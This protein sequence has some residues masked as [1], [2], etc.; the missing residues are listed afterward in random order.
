MV[1]RQRSLAAAPRLALLLAAVVTAI[2]SGQTSTTTFQL[3]G[4]PT[5]L[6]G[7]A[8]GSTFN[9][10]IGP[11]GTLVVAGTG[12]V[13]FGP[14][15]AATGV[16]FRPGGWQANDIAYY[17]F[18]GQA[19]G[20]IFNVNGGD[21]TFL[22]KSRSSFANR[23]LGY[24]KWVFDVYD[25][26][27]NLFTFYVATNSGTLSFNYRA[28][29]VVTN[30]YV[31]PPGQED[32]MFGSGVVLKV[33]VAWNGSRVYL[34]LN[35]AL[36][37]TRTY[38]PV[39]PTWTAASSFVIGTRQDLTYGAGYFSWDDWVSQLVVTSAASGSPPAKVGSPSPATGAVGVATTSALSW[40]ASSGATSYDVYFGHTLPAF[41]AAANLAATTFAPSGPLPTATSYV[42]RVDAKNAFG[43]TAGD[44]WSFTTAGPPLPPKV[45]SPSPPHGSANVAVSAAL[46]WAA[47]TGATTYDLYVGT[48]LPGSPTWTNMTGTT[49]SPPGGFA[50]STKYY[51]RVDAKNASGATAGDVWSFTTSAATPPPPKP[52]TPSPAH[53][54]TNVG[55][56]TTLAWAGSAGATGYDVYLGTTLPTAPTVSGL[57]ATTYAPGA[58]LAY[59]T[60]YSWRVDAKNGGGTTAGDVWTFTTGPAP[61]VSSVTVTSTADAAIHAVV[62][63]SNLGHAPVVTLYAGSSALHAFSLPP[64]P[65][66]AVLLSARLQ[67]SVTGYDDGYPMMADEYCVVGVYRLTRPWTEGGVTHNMA[68]ATTAWTAAGGDYDST[69]DFGHGAN[70][71]VA[72]ALSRLSQTPES[73][74]FDVTALV[75]KWYSNSHPNYGFLL[76]QSDRQGGPMMNFKEVADTTKRPM[77][78]IS[79]AVTTAAPTVVSVMPSN[80]AANRPVDQPITLALNDLVGIN[81]G[82]LSFLVN[83]V[84]RASQV[85]VSGPQRSPTLTYAPA[86]AFGHATSVNAT[87]SIQNWSGYTLTS[88]ITFTVA[89]TDTVAPVVARGFPRAGATNVPTTCHVRVL[90]PGPRFGR[91]LVDAVRQIERDR[92]H[93]GSPDASRE[94]RVP[95]APHPAIS[96]AGWTASDVHGHQLR[97]SAAAELPDELHLHLHHAAGGQLV[98]RHASTSTPATT[99]T[100]PS[101]RAPSPVPPTPCARSAT[102]S[103]SSPSTSTRT[104]PRASCGHRPSCRRWRRRRA[105]WA[106]AGLPSLAGRSSTPTRGTRWCSGCHGTRIPKPSTTCRRTHIHSSASLP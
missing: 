49:Y 87:L 28:G 62:P 32:A 68:T 44:V 88:G 25:A 78:V 56:G 86:N 82:S 100:T 83:G 15:G 38:A 39:V 9:P 45:A 65:G 1:V 70:G 95:A 12:V 30:S 22:L 71:V 99:R 90:A 92:H 35:D 51:W 105:P 16:A 52:A 37:Q 106:T 80:G 10:P 4:E 67:L 34:Y 94:R 98:P 85:R 77:L 18:G 5:E 8:G 79:Y 43:T 63:A 101:R 6:L 58:P 46:S 42:W 41:P 53:L 81:P 7:V 73:L 47:A 36:V 31:V 55:V 97:Q 50:A 104:P 76:R 21:V 96:V 74:T 69:S 27:Q 14:V 11:Q 29:G 23:Q 64:L 17:S 61:A 66:G 3:K 40:A 26:G 59:G 57:T 33:R 20:S 48:T 60:T 91:R 24:S 19:V 2:T 84:Q 75:A 89:P 93:G 103:W 102:G 54:A 72:E 13:E